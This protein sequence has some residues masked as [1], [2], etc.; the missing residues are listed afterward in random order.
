MFGREKNTW[1]LAK[2]AETFHSSIHPFF[3]K[4]DNGNYDENLIWID[5]C[6]RQVF[7]APYFMHFFFAK[8]K[9]NFP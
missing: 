9:P 7:M 5:F 2:L 6:F 8:T 4:V 1:R 3:E